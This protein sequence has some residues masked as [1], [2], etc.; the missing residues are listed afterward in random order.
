MLATAYS[1]GRILEYDRAGKLVWEAKATSPIGSVRLPN[2]N[3]LLASQ[4]GV[5]LELDRNG[6]TVWEHKIAGHPTRVRYR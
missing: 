2:G 4:T 3:T 6:K 5:V 1:A